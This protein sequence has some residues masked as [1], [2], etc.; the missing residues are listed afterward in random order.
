MDIR[1]AAYRGRI[2]QA[3]RDDFHCG[4][5]LGLALLNGAR[6]ARRDERFRTTDRSDPGS[7]VLG[8]KVAAGD[9]ADVFVDI[10]RADGVKLFVVIDV[11]EEILTWQ[12]VHALHDAG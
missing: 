10:A 9:F 2:A 5:S 8:R 12:V 6:G 3:S 1:L 7:E 11:R 4:G